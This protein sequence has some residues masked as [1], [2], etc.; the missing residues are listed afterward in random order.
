M[1][2]FYGLMSTHIYPRLNQQMAMAIGGEDRP[3]WIS[4]TRWR[5]FAAQAGINGAYTL[6]LLR[7]M[8]ER[9]PQIGALV[10]ER[11]QRQHGFASVVRDIRRLIEQRARQ[12]LVLLQAEAS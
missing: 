10:A 12:V 5:D 8:A 11:F 2:P 6:S 4:P 1:A 7:D 3:D 9:I